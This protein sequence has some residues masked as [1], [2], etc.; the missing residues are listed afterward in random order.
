MERNVKS[1]T[2][3]DSLSS[4]HH[5]F[6]LGNLGSTDRNINV[7]KFEFYHV[8]REE[9]LVSGAIQRLVWPSKESLQDS[10]VGNLFRFIV[11]ALIFSHKLLAYHA[12]PHHF[13]LKAR[14]V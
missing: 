7:S 3:A 13:D 14:G 9:Y 1:V 4:S 5:R 10:S 8:L 2:R 6:I 12:H 11:S